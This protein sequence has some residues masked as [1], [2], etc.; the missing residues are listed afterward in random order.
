MTAAD[1]RNAEIRIA[2]KGT[3]TTA[4]LEHMRNWKR[5]WDSLRRNKSAIEAAAVT[6]AERIRCA[7]SETSDPK[8]KGKE[9]SA[10]KGPNRFEN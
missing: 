7:G 9:N 2:T 10:L 5:N 3:L 8:E 6:T 4:Q 1:I